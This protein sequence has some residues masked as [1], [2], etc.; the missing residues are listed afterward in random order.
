MSSD[1]ELTQRLYMAFVRGAVIG[2]VLT[3]IGFFI[4]WYFWLRPQE[5]TVKPI[6]EEAERKNREYNR[7]ERSQNKSRATE[8]NV[9]RRIFNAL[10]E[11][12]SAE[13]M[14]YFCSHRH[15]P[16]LGFEVSVRPYFGSNEAMLVVIVNCS[17]KFPIRVEPGLWGVPALYTLDL[18]E[19]AIEESKKTLA[20]L[21]AK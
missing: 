5:Q 1:L 18:V 13:R 11:F 19:S 12:R 6:V 15:I 10:E 21:W 2:T 4:F 16:Q 7:E 8:G 20:L 9:G 3:S 14:T 17:H